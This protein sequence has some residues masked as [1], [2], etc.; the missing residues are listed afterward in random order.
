MNKIKL[1]LIILYLLG[2]SSCSV[3]PGKTE[4]IS[5]ADVGEFSASIESLLSD[6]VFLR[7]EVRKINA[8]KPS[9]QRII[10]GAD[11]FW[12]KGNLEE[13]SKELERALRISRNESAVFLRLAQIRSEQGLKLES[14]GFAARGLMINGISSWERFLLRVYTLDK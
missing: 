11:A 12:K 8:S 3:N 10:N 5:I 9:I 4:D 6:P 1:I 13:S 7:N 14:G 2:L